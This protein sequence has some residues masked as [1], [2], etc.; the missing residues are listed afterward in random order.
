VPAQ[1]A[2]GA[3]HLTEILAQRLAGIA[4][5][6]GGEILAGGRRGIEKESLRITP[7]GLIAQTPHPRSLGSALTNKY[8]TTDYSEALLEFVTPPEPNAWSAMQFMC[9]L[10]QFT[11]EGIDEELL[12][13]F[14][15]PC[16]LRS[17]TDIPLAQYGSSNI[18]QMKTIYRNGLGLRYG[19]YMQVI[20]GIHFNYSLPESFW[21]V[22]ADITA[23]KADTTALKSH[24]Y[25]GLVRNV[26]RMDW[27]LLYL[28]GASPAICE[29]F[30][31]GAAT[32][33][34][35]L[36]SGTYIGPWATS[37]RMSDLGYQNSNQARLQVSANSLD[38]YVRDLSAAIVTPNADY[39]QLGLQEHDEYL[40]LNC[41]QLQ[42]ENE[43]YSTIRPKRVARSGERPTSA[44]HR[45]GVEYVELRA[46]DI[47][48]FDPTGIGQPQ[49]KFLEAFLI[50]C[51]LLDSPPVSAD[52]Y[53]EIRQN[54][55][56][57]ARR[58][59]EPGLQLL[60]GGQAVGVAARAAEIC[61][62]MRPICEL[63]DQPGD[64]SY[65]AALD[66]QLA[67]SLDSSKTP[68]ARLLTELSDSGDSF[69]DFGLQLA[70]DYKTYFDGLEPEFNGH[71]EI[72]AGES[73]A[74]VGRQAEI[75]AADT[76]SLDEYL[77]RYYA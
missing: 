20:S 54:H 66:L 33:L 39:V 11:Y 17:E 23:S 31:Q 12:W 14:S 13:P 28:F 24:S 2:Q 5:N 40:Q 47:S 67:A 52:E 30:L 46:L 22:W 49:Q 68:S 36:S 50:Y 4:S 59:R 44:L 1:Q 43:Y 27:L 32:D 72:F 74:S 62:Q 38:E 26:R 41:N 58:G 37:L 69:A 65:T 29:S 51:L 77:E 60:Q 19:R 71:H 57:I 64:N 21:P 3:I 35:L 15:M 48:P 7:D 45:G 76:L 63:L 56:Q 16:R 73:K 9:D 25:M 42:I 8:I 70:R 53:R 75:E 61:Q 55:A 34:E 18:G 10:H 6:G